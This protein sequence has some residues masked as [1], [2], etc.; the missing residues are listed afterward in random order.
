[1]DI[2]V[3]G[4]FNARAANAAIVGGMGRG[5]FDRHCGGLH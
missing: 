5:G 4:G 3:G 1:M 2:G